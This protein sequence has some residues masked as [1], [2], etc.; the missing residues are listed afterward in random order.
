[1][2]RFKG[3]LLCAERSKI[4]YEGY[5]L[6][7]KNGTCGGP[8]MR[9]CGVTMNR[10]LC[11]PK[12]ESCPINSIVISKTAMDPK[13]VVDGNYK[14]IELDD[15]Y[16][17]YFSNQFTENKI[18]TEFK[19][20]YE[21][22]CLSPDEVKVPADYET[23]GLDNTIYHV[24]ECKNTMGSSSAI[25]PRWTKEI[26][27]SR[28]SLFNENGY[29]R[30]YESSYTINMK[31]LDVP[32]HY[33]YSRGYSDWDR[34]CMSDPNKS[35]NDNLTDLKS[36]QEGESKERLSIAAIVLLS[37]AIVAAFL[38]L[39]SSFK[40]KDILK[41]TKSCFVWLV[42]LLLAIIIILGILFSRA[43]KDYPEN[44]ENW[45][46]EE[47]GDETTSAII[48]KQLIINPNCYHMRDGFWD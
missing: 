3:K 43:F 7:P 13:K 38:W 33:I 22:P 45:M 42:I 17:M 47:C 2:H 36:D 28:L 48:K 26:S 20:T 35:I 46:K 24:E 39:I 44:S 32:N 10:K 31:S 29:F 11:L 37:I 9:V 19:T 30:G 4:S 34:Q 12:T 25:D 14:T 15:G 21:S 16:N 6:I 18:I 23:G 1:M 27:V 40:D 41:Y 8:D 5:K